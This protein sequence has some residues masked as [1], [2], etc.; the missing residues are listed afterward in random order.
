MLA[1]KR[2]AQ[3]SFCIAWCD[4]GPSACAQGVQKRLQA[5]NRVL[6]TQGATFLSTRLPPQTK[7]ETSV[8]S[9]SRRVMAVETDGDQ[10]V[11]THEKNAPTYTETTLVKKRNHTKIHKPS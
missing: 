11:A 10:S 6:K 7:M 9:G 4:T 8:R 3:V 1:T 5:T 2:N